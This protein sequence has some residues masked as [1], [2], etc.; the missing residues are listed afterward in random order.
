MRARGRQ[1][2]GF[3]KSSCSSKPCRAVLALSE[4]EEKLTAAK[5]KASSDREKLFAE[6]KAKVKKY[7]AGYEKLVTK[8]A[9]AFGKGDLAS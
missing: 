9:E 4:L 5:L 2:K 8:A 3:F 6:V 7:G 1:I